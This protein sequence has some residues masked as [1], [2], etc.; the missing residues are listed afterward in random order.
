MNVTDLPLLN[1][2]LN[3]VSL[4][5]LISGYKFIKRGAREKHKRM[6]ISALITSGL[7]LTSYLVYHG[8]VGSVP[9]PRHDWTRPLYFLILVPHVILAALMGPFIIAAVILALKEK[10]IWHVRLVKWVWPVW[11]FVSGSGVMVFLML[12]VY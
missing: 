2:L 5:F 11:I 1:A 9:Y 10:F 7:F 3:M 8:L 12:Y 4:G 6:M